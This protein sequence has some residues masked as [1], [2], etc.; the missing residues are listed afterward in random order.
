MNRIADALALLRFHI[1]RLQWPALAGI[2]LG[3]FAVTV[4]FTGVKGAEEGLGRVRAEMAQLR[5]GQAPGADRGAISI[6]QRLAEFQE[7]LPPAS[8][9]PDALAGVYDAAQANGMALASA[10]YK[11]TREKGSRLLRYQMSLPVRG[12]YSQVRTWLAEV[13]NGAPN[14]VLED[15]SLKR[16]SA[17]S[18]ALDG[19]A[20]LSLYFRLP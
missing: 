9:L 2:G 3:A 10:E 7:F 1:G 16:E 17:G 19:R 12:T 14:A 5:A 15:L 4:Y 6:E 13:M 11:E 20:R 8:A 18:E